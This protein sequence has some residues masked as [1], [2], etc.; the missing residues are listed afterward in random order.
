MNQIHLN[1]K[2]EIRFLL[3]DPN[4]IK[5]FS[6]HYQLTIYLI[7]QKYLSLGQDIKKYLVEQQ[8]LLLFIKIYNNYIQ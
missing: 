1:T 7:K 4:S 3:I 5:F 2:S 8:I 6:T